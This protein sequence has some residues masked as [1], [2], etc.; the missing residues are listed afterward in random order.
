MSR[1]AF[2]DAA[3]AAVETLGLSRSKDLAG[4]LAR[5]RTRERILIELATPGVSEAVAKLYAAMESDAV[6]ASEA[7]AYLRGYVAAR[8]HTR[9]AVQVRTVWSGPSTPG[10]PV[11]ATAQVLVEVINEAQQELLAMTYAA[12]PYPALT[13][14]LT[15]AADRGS[16]RTLW[17]KPWPAP[18]VCCREGNRPKHSHPCLVCCCGSGHGTRSIG[19]AHAS[20]P[21]SRSPTVA[22]SCSAVPT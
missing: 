6:P 11:R 7:A 8:R 5:G 19:T 9:D 10:V 20:T 18:A 12:R 4:L 14:A 15:A 13:K 16:R 3:E 2:E 17:S 22:L 1:P 21:S